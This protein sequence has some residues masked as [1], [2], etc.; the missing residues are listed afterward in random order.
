MSRVFVQH[1]SARW[2]E[3]HRPR[4]FLGA[5]V[6]SIVG[7]VLVLAALAVLLVAAV[8]AIPVGLV[9]GAVWWV[10][11]RLARIGPRHDGRRNVRVRGVRT[12]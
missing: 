9:V 3:V 10:R 8:I 11:D 1:V 7:T 6:L 2:R 4:T 12:E 5:L